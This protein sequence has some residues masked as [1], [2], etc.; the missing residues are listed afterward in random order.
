MGS[1]LAAQASESR[2]HADYLGTA[3]FGSLDGLRCLSIVAVIWHHAG[4]ADNGWRLLD[5]GFLGVDLFF[6]ISGF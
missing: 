2:A 4:R 3:A 6:V 1:I 5:R